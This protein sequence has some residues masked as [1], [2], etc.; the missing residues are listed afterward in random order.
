MLWKNNYCCYHHHN[1]QYQSLHHFSSHSY[2]LPQMFFSAPRPSARHTSGACVAYR[3]V[4]IFGTVA[5][6]LN[7]IL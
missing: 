7:H 4:D 3:D 2:S 5:V 1:N 6:N